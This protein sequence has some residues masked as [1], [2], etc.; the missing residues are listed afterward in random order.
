MAE[1]LAQSKI[2]ASDD[3]EL[4]DWCIEQAQASLSFL[5]FFFM[6]A[7]PDAASAE[8]VG[9]VGGGNYSKEVA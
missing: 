3:R 7:F 5:S 1:G 2:S 9:Y 6:S 4:Y 8:T